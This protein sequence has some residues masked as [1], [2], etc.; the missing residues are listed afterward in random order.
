MNI[1]IEI[2]MA[3]I[4]M[5]LAGYAMAM[6]MTFEEGPFEIF[7]KIRDASG[8]ITNEYGQR[9]PDS[10]LSVI[11]ENV[12]KAL[13]CPYCTSVY[14][15]FFAFI[16]ILFVSGFSVHTILSYLAALGVARYMINNEVED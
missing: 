7:S 8:I 16:V 5:G 4:S 15:T 9:V 14:T 6:L 13:L 3:S 10:E 11:K 1:V 2:L 12:A